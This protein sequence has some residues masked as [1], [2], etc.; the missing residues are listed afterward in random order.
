MLRHRRN[1]PPGYTESALK[2]I[3][4]KAAEFIS[5]LKKHWLVAE[6]F[7]DGLKM[8][9][10]WLTVKVSTSAGGRPPHVQ[11]CERCGR[12]AMQS[13]GPAAR[14]RCTPCSRTSWT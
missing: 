10:G 3:A 14:R 1:Q 2:A 6:F 8:G 13:D 11:T 12:H 5:L 4:D 9:V 7:P